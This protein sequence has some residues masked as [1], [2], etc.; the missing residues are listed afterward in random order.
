MTS[1]LLRFRDSENDIWARFKARSAQ[2]GIPM[3]A[4]VLKLIELYANGEVTINAVTRK[5]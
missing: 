3:R 1:Y 5:G 4:L 2:E